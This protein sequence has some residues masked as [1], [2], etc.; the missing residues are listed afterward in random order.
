MLDNKKIVENKKFNINNISL[1][2][3]YFYITPNGIVFNWLLHYK[4]N[5]INK[6][7]DYI[8]VFLESKEITDVISNK[9][10]KIFN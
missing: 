10:K 3:N 4:D 1:E 2:K 6:E 7:I 8:S 9:F 5:I